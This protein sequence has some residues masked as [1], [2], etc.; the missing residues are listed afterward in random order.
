V[1]LY[2]NLLPDKDILLE[3]IMVFVGS[4]ATAAVA[5]VAAIIFGV[6]QFQKP[7]GKAVAISAGI[8]LVG[9]TAFVLVVVYLDW[10]ARRGMPL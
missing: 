7:V 8:A 2:G 10:S 9:L 6:T 1:E 5:L 4:V 3:S